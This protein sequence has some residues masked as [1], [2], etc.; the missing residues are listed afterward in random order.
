MG[1]P[2]DLELHIVRSI[3]DV[4]A[5]KTWLGE[6]RDIMGLDIETSGLD[7]FKP[8]ARIRS[9][10]V[11]DQRHG[12][13]VPYE[14]WGG[15]ALEILK[16]W[17]G[18]IALHNSAF[19]LKFLQLHA[20]WEVP[21]N[22]IHD[23]MIMAQ[24]MYP[25]KPAGLK[26]LSAKYVDPRANI[27]EK[28]LKQAFKDN[29]WT[30]DTV[31]IYEPAFCNYSAID[32]IITT[33][34]WDHLRADLVY[35]KVFSIE[36]AARALHTQMEIRGMRLDVDYTVRMEKEL[37]EEVEQKKKWAQDN[38]GINIMS[39]AQLAKFLADDLGAEFTHFSDK[40]GAPSVNKAQLAKFSATGDETIRAVVGFVEDAKSKQK[41]ANT[42]F[43]NYREM[44]VEGIIHPSINTLGASTTGRSS[45]SNPNAQNLPSKDYLVR[46][47]FIADNEDHEIWS[48]DYSSAELRMLAHFSEDPGMIDAFRRVD[49]LDEDFFTTLGK[50]IYHDKNFDR[51]DPRRKLVK[52]FLYG[53]VYGS[54]VPKMAETTGESVETMQKVS[55][56][57]FKTYPKVRQFMDDVIALGEHR[58]SVEKIP[59]IQF[60][61]TGRRLVTEP[62][63][64][65]RLV[66]YLLQGQCAEWTKR[67][68]IDLDQADLSQYVK[69]VVHDEYIFSFPKSDAEE[70]AG[71][72]AEAM[73]FGEDDG[74]IVPQV[75][76]P[77]RSGPRWGSKY[78]Q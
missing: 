40:T 7:A 30:W 32:P 59:Y 63:T 51:S 21:W 47:A 71:L 4:L 13:F 12:W 53:T 57:F 78:H 77:E 44:A 43:K 17:E 45:S 69:L 54:G 24:I 61:T 1:L 75:A 37:S 72:A 60:P 49:N 14:L 2:A 50:D 70:L 31:P 33:Y 10:Q 38:W 74:L 29:D 56:S 8:G 66:N 73:S 18:N 39:N 23:T 25:G 3:D 68:L 42:Y 15:A 52:S 76:E 6:R 65:Y 67:A 16:S 28:Y 36:M 35:P 5:M 9:I 19:D 22:R 48:I 27:G 41:I 20:G 55:D 11:G 64:E 34:L 46:D 58:A 62:G 26:E